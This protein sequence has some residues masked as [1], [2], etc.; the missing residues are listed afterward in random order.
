MPSVYISRPDP[1]LVHVGVA[2]RL[3]NPSSDRVTH[4][5]NVLS[6]GNVLDVAPES[7]QVLALDNAEH[8]LLH[9]LPANHTR[10]V[11]GFVEQV[12]DELP[13]LAVTPSVSWTFPKIK[14][15]LNFN[16][17]VQSVCSS[18]GKKII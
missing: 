6:A 5:D 11:L 12:P 17:N 2:T 15:K 3:R 10:A 13:Q 18:S 8:A 9:V 1:H 4:P 16:K 7:S 14:Q